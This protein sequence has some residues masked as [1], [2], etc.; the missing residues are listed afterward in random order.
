MH[1]VRKPFTRSAL[2][3]ALAGT[4]RLKTW[5]RSRRAGFSGGIDGQVAARPTMTRSRCCRPGAVTTLWGLGFRLNNSAVDRHRGPLDRHAA[6][7]HLRVAWPS[8]H[9]GSSGPPGSRERLSYEAQRLPMWL[10]SGVCGPLLAP[11]RLIAR[12]LEAKRVGPIGRRS[13][14]KRLGRFKECTPAVRQR[15]ETLRHLAKKRQEG[16]RSRCKSAR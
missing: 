5:R 8:Q 1:W 7:A 6:I 16:P 14:T 4:P 10:C 13:D 9:G 15:E 11:R 3:A 2:V 12:G